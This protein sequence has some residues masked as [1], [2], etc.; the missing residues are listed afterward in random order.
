LKLALEHHLAGISGPCPGCGSQITAPNHTTSQAG[1][2]FGRQKHPSR[3]SKGRIVAD[4]A[5][6]YRHLERRESTK[7]LWIIVMFILAFCACLLVT[8]FMKDWINQ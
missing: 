7:T 4:S 1:T 8:W 6:D 3:A 2:A 5:V